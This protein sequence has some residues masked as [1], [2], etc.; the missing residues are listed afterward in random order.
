M[1]GDSRQWVIYKRVT[2]HQWIIERVK[3]VK[4]PFELISPNLASEELTLDVGPKE[5]KQLQVK[6]EKLKCKMLLLSQE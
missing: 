2:Y 6:V 1:E 5:V 3:K 4:L